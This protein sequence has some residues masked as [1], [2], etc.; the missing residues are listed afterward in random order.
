MSQ[1]SSLTQWFSP[2]SDPDIASGAR[3]AFNL[4]QRIVTV[5]A[6]GVL[7]GLD[8]IDGHVAWHVSL[9]GSD[10][11]LTHATILAL[12]A[13]GLSHPIYALVATLSTGA[14][15]IVLF[16]PLTGTVEST[17]TH[18]DA[19]AAYGTVALKHNSPLLVLTRAG[20]LVV[21]P[22][23]QDTLA[24]VQAHVALQHTVLYSAD[25]ATGVFEGFLV[26]ATADG[27][28]SLWWWWWWLV[29]G[30]EDVSCNL[31]KCIIWCHVFNSCL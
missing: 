15:S 23:T 25:R 9:L 18:T 28:L 10:S 12:H 19:I 21:Y 7:A 30:G 24:A 17:A 5:S 27:T 8:S 6:S 4:H 1:V 11:S 26:T 14:T 2:S 29:V 31:K 22:Q 16:D 20:D 13:D 3:D